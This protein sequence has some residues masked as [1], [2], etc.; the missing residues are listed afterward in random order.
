MYAFADGKNMA[1]VVILHF[2][3]ESGCRGPVVGEGDVLES[4]EAEPT[5]LG[6]RA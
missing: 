6:F 1:L 3:S 2:C 5:G 4:M